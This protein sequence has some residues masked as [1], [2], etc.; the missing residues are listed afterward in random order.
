MNWINLGVAADFQ[1]ETFYIARSF[2]LGI[3]RT[4]ARSERRTAL[5]AESNGSVKPMSEE[6]TI[7]Q[8]RSFIVERRTQIDN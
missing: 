7:Y 4:A 2:T 8:S 3:L 1:I 6:L 5:E